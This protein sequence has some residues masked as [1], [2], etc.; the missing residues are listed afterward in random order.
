MMISPEVSPSAEQRHPFNPNRHYSRRP[1]ISFECLLCGQ[2]LP[3]LIM[4]AIACPCGNLVLAADAGRIS[5]KNP[6]QVEVVERLSG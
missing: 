3:S 6:H 1:N 4:Y 2:Q 5:A